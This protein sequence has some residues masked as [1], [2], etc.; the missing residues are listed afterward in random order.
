V[1]RWIVYCLIGVVLHKYY[2]QLPIILDW[3]RFWLD[4]VLW[5]FVIIWDWP[6]FAA[7]LSPETL[8]A[9]GP[10]FALAMIGVF[11]TFLNK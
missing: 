11:L 3:G 10:L 6:S 8:K 5:P 7:H 9:M 4:V 1:I 2:W